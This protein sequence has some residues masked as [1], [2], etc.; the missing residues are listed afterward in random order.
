MAWESINQLLVK[1][2]VGLFKAS[3]HYVIYDLISGN[4]V[5]ICKEERLGFFTKLLRFSDYS[6]M[7]PFA[8]QIR[9][10]ENKLILEVSRGISLVFST[11]VVKDGNKR[12]IGSFKQ[13]L[14]SIGGKFAVLDKNDKQISMLQGSWTGWNF[15]FTSDQVE[16]AQVTKEWAG[17]GKELLTTADNYVLNYSAYLKPDSELKRLILAAVMCI[18]M[19]LKE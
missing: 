10:M 15:K 18:D 12:V 14:F 2:H 8:L 11:V 1:E 4:Q 5:L 17:I 19:V 16:H 6:R 3:K 13:Q 9:D 7:T